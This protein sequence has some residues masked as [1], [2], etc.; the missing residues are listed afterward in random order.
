MKFTQVRQHYDQ[1]GQRLIE[2]GMSGDRTWF[3]DEKCELDIMEFFAKVI[4]EIHGENIE[5][6]EIVRH[7]SVVNEQLF[8]GNHEGFSG[9]E[10]FFL[11]LVAKD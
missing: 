1:L 7:K 3:Y 5:D 4:G 10:R 11:V 2:S 6:I 8:E 9:L